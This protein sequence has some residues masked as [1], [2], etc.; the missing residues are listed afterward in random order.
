MKK[1]ISII[2]AAAL[3]MMLVSCVKESAGLT[4]I[5]YYPTITLTGDEYVF[6]TTGTTFT[7]PGYAAVMNGEDVTSQ[8]EVITDLDTSTPGLYTIAYS[9]VNSDGISAA[10][11]RYVIVRDADDT[12]SGWYTAATGTNRVYNGPIPYSGYKILIYPYGVS[13]IYNVT[14]LLAGW[15]D[16]RAGYG[17]N[18]AC[19]GIIRVTGA[20]V[21]M[22]KGVVPGWASYPVSMTGGAYV[23]AT[24][25]ISYTLN[26]A[27]MDFFIILNK[28]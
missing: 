16:Q 20:A 11:N 28:D 22:L 2:I 15:Y 3:A 9:M 25:T 8:V 10:A 4:R 12:V 5:T 24:G 26:F 17:S 13:G 23:A 14:D 18:Y 19:V 27:G 6:V 21:T 1:Y 7:D